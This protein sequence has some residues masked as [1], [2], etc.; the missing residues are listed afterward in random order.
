VSHGCDAIEE[1][2]ALGFVQPTPDPVWFTDPNG[3]L[4]AVQANA[5]G[6][7]DPLGR[8]LTDQALLLAFDVRRRKKDDGVR[9]T[10][11]GSRLPQLFTPIG[12][13]V[14]PPT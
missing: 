11:G 5:T 4:E 8:T 9:P 7:T 13:H 2:L 12:D 10:T 3:V 14:A 6:S 1:L